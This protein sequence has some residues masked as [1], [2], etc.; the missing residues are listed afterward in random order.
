MAHNLPPSK[1]VSLPLVLSM[2]VIVIAVALK[3]PT[4]WSLNHT[5]ARIARW[6]VEQ[7][8]SAEWW[9]QPQNSSSC[10][11]F[12]DSGQ[13]SRPEEARF[14]RLRVIAAL[15]CDDF[16]TALQLFQSLKDVVTLRD[17]VPILG[18][19]PLK[20]GPSEVIPS[21]PSEISHWGIAV[22]QARAAFDRGDREEA[23]VWLETVQDTLAEPPSYGRKSLYFSACFIY[24]R[25]SRLERSLSACQKLVAISPKDA[26]AWNLLGLTWLATKNLEEAEK[27][28]SK[29][30]TLQDGRWA[31]PY[32]NLGRVFLARGDGEAARREI[33]VA[34]SIA[35][36][37]PWANY[38]MAMTLLEQKDCEGAAQYLQLSLE[39]ENGTTQQA[40]E[41]LLTTFSTICGSPP[42]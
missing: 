4:L 19:V 15:S 11:N 17:K 26:E 42:P 34:L 3:I 8:L 22:Q 18:S 36:A 21:V 16:D 12:T 33:E 1:R 32:I 9:L 39:P 5:A 31:S 2:A 7:G 13:F 27:A 20:N 10:L 40:A 14:T 38:Y 25:A 6:Q 35:P 28:F 30:I 23:V 41:Q 37:N 29:A 24:R